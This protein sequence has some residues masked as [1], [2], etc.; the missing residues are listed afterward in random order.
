MS[1]VAV[2]T[3][4]AAGIPEDMLEELRIHTIP[5]YIH[6]GSQVLRDLVNISY[7][8]FYKWLPTLDELPTTANPSPGDYLEKYKELA[9]Q[10]FKNIISIQITS[11]GSGAYKAAL[12][13]KEMLRESLPE[14]KL[15]VID[16]LNASMCQGWMAVEAARAAL[17]GRSLPD[18][19]ALVKKMIPISHMFQTTDT[20]RYLYMGG[21]I[22]KAKHLVASMLNI[23]PI[24]GMEEGVVVAL[25]QAR[26]RT[27]V[28]QTMADKMSSVVS[29]GAVKVA[30]VHAAAIEE[31]Q[32]LKS[33]VEKRIN[34]AESIFSQ[35]SPALGVHTGPGTVG[36]CY[37][38]LPEG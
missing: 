35:F 10:G 17:A 12:I 5:F 16:S 23:K 29:A 22:G 20:L 25:G 4:S 9:A 38:P 21:R 6:H 30:Y 28:Y 1:K 18:I 15:D 3:D 37:Y 19:S 8:K 14:I 36:L 34:V 13:A 24:I 31:A 2:V 7:E 33:I 26:N 27:K 32:K 11:L